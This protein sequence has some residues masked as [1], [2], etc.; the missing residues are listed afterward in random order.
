MNKELG[1]GIGIYTSNNF[2]G[3]SYVLC[4]EVISDERAI[5]ISVFNAYD[6][7]EVLKAR[8]YKFSPRKKY[9]DCSNGAE[10]EAASWGKKF[11]SNDEALEEMKFLLANITVN[12][13]SGKNGRPQ[14]YGPYGKFTRC[15]MNYA[16]TSKKESR[17]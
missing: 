16:C 5:V 13:I 9:N 1:N 8:G 6:H 15:E 3:A 10:I 2:D 12:F 4:D 17:I 14:R 7:R 11:T